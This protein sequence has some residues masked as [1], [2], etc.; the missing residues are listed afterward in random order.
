MKKLKFMYSDVPRLRVVRGLNGHLHPN[1]P[2][3]PK[4]IRIGNSIGPH[5]GRF[6]PKL[7][8]GF[9]SVVQSS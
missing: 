6:R 4:E 5:L 2:Q 8:K 9:L 7:E 1:G 3:N